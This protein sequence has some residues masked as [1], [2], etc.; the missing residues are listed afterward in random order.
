MAFLFDQD[1]S[2]RDISDKIP[3]YFWPPLSTNLTDLIT[4]VQTRPP[5]SLQSPSPRPHRTSWH[6]PRRTS[7]QLV[8]VVKSLGHTDTT[9]LWEWNLWVYLLISE[10]HHSQARLWPW[11]V[12]LLVISLGEGQGWISRTIIY[13]MNNCSFFWNTDILFLFC[14]FIKTDKMLIRMLLQQL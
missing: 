5:S 3:V 12:W 4:I 6:L 7:Q 2:G 13:G 9:D 11:P 10:L 14:L 1:T 8:D